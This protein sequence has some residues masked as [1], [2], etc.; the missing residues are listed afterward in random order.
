MLL[1]ILQLYHSY[2]SIY[3]IG[4]LWKRLNIKRKKQLFI[5]LLT[6]LFSGFSEII[7]IGSFIPFISVLT[8]SNNIQTQGLFINF[9]NSIS[10]KFSVSLLF[11][12]TISFSLAAF[13]TIFIRLLNIWYTENLVALI[14]HDFSLEAYKKT[15]CQPYD[16]HLY[17][18]SSELIK[19]ITI[20]IDKT[21]NVINQALRMITSIFLLFFIFTF[22]VFT[23]WQMAIV[24][25]LFFSFT[26]YFIIF[27][28]R[29]KL[30]QNSKKIN[31][32]RSLQIQSIQEGLGS[33]K[34]LII[35]NKQFE[36]INYYKNI[37]LPLRKWVAQNRLIS[38]SP[39]YLIEGISL[40]F[41][42]LISYFLFNQND[43]REIIPILGAIALGAQKM[44]PHLQQVF[45]SWA[46]IKSN[47][48]DLRSVL[49]TIEQPFDQDFLSYI[50]RPLN[51]SSEIEFKN[52]SY[53]YKGSRSYAL[54]NINLKILKGEIV[55][56]IGT[57]GSGKTSFIDLLM[58]LLEPDSGEIRVDNKSLIGNTYLKKEWYASISHVAQDIFLLDNSIAENIA[59][60]IKRNEIDFER[61]VNVS[62]KAQIYEFILSLPK[63][64]DTVIGER[65]INLSGGQR[66]R[67]AIA[68][69]LYSESSLIIFDEATSALDNKTEE[70]IMESINTLDNAYTVV[71]VAHRLSSLK[72]CKKIFRFN[73][74]VLE[75]TIED[76]DINKL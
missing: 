29:K 26:Y 71:M 13:L 11:L 1:Q 14:G 73:N 66:Q 53:K 10:L 24:S 59:F 34:D 40:I 43:S 19:I 52:V 8:S 3:L 36:Y 39:R 44:L 23:D 35:N 57:T 51:F 37:D 17:R 64:F 58:G 12:L 74:G 65:G 45:K 48:A 62:K 50:N 5:L 60:G 16:V 38:N 20:Q 22:L 15:I 72:N 28:S 47:S 55:G 69:S 56:I 4:Q 67:I 30:V 25:L 18:N 32:T 76:F 68:K 31:T 70:M 27:L 54:N 46:S 21:I 9:L 49:K 75:Q 61:L 6:I 42:S 63:G 2:N 7:S 41:I 33:I